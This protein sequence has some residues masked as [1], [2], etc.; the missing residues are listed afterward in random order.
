VLQHVSDRK[1]VAERAVYS[2]N[3]IHVLHVHADL[4]LLLVWQRG[5]TE[6]TKFA[7]MHTEHHVNITQSSKFNKVS[8]IERNDLRRTRCVTLK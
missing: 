8:E 5:E 3:V 7:I 2:I 6:G 4:D 1:D